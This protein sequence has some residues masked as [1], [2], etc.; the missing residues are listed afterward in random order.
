MPPGRITR[1]L[2]WLDAAVVHDFI[3]RVV[4]VATSDVNFARSVRVW[5]PQGHVVL[6]GGGHYHAP[7]A[8]GKAHCGDQ[9]TLAS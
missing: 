6:V 4:R 2:H 7:T 8:R 5:T 9:Q 1:V 3:A